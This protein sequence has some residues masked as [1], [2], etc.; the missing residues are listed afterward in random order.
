M[1]FHIDTVLY[2][3]P[4]IPYANVTG[5]V[6][7]PSYPRVGDLLQLMGDSDA[8][9]SLL[10][11]IDEVRDDASEET[12]SITLED[13]VVE[14]PGLVERLGERLDKETRFHVYVYG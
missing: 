12:G 13:H 6:E 7:L 10:L 11:R 8:G 5:Y 14:G 4:N 2:S 9:P 3:T 1:R